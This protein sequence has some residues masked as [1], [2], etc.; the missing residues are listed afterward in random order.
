MKMKMK[1]DQRCG[2]VPRHGYGGGG[3]RQHQHPA[4]SLEASVSLL[5]LL[6]PHTPL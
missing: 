5:S 2:A 1:K 3:G 6:T 4:F